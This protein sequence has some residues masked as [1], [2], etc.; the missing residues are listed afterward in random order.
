MNKK[1]AY[2]HIKMPLEIN[3]DG[4]IEP[5]KEYITIDFTLCNELPPKHDNDVNYAFVMN[6]L[7]TLFKTEDAADETQSYVEPIK[8]SILKEEMKRCKKKVNTSFKNNVQY[9]NRNTLKLRDV[10]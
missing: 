4:T 8:L 9:K 6:N 1:Y 7:N 2:A 10:L 3:E 5:L